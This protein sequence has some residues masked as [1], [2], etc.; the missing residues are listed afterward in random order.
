MQ[1][2]FKTVCLYDILTAA[3]WLNLKYCGK[4]FKEATGE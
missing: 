2:I 4:S 3:Q 1:L